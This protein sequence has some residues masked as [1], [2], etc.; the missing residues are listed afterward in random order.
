MD[1][2]DDRDQRPPAEGVRIIGAEE[3]QAALE[4]GRAAGRRAEHQ[5]AGGKPDDRRYQPGP[6]S[7]EGGGAPDWASRSFDA[8]P[9]A[10][11][12]PSPD[13]P[14]PAEPQAGPDGWAQEVHDVTD[15]SDPRGPDQ[16]DEA[17]MPPAE[18]VE[19]RYEPAPAPTVFDAEQE[20]DT[21]HPD[22]GRPAGESESTA[23]R[24]ITL[25]GHDLPHWTDPPTGEAPRI[26]TNEPEP[27][28]DDLA[29]WQALGSQGSRWRDGA[30]DWD[31]VEEL[32]SLGSEETRV[33]AL[34]TSRSEHS[35]IYSFDEDFERLEEQRSAPPT[36]APRVFGEPDRAPTGSFAAAPPPGSGEEVAERRPPPSP[37]PA[38]RRQEGPSGPGRPPRRPGRSREPVDGPGS[39][40]EGGQLGQRLAVGAALVV[41][42]LIFYAIGSA[43]LMV[44]SAAIIGAAAAEG[45]GMLQ[46]AG[47]RPATLLG[48]VSSVAIVGAAYWRGQGALPLVIAL[49]FAGSMLW[50]LLGIVDAR[51]L[52]N[53]AVTNL[54]FVWVGVLGSFGALLLRAHDGRGLFLGAVIV[55]VG[56]DIAAYFA[57]S[58][59]GNRPMAPSVSP[60]KTWEGAA[61]GL[62]AAL[63]IGAIIGKAV[64]PWGG[65]KHGLVFG[66]LVGIVGPIGDLSESMIKRD[67]GIKN[68]GTLIP[69][70][71]GLLD[72]FDAVLF[73]LPVAYYLAAWTGI[74]R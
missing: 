15:D 51:P 25:G 12:D 39:G 20:D 1:E 24:P 67:L 57:G 42:L 61:A 7:Y 64:D 50:Y 40:G 68:S 36:P 49:T 33:G 18:D 59:L 38:P 73:V 53:I 11:D 34:D 26:L 23:E 45:Y 14:G 3:A 31:D 29:A 41:L 60:G 13:D 19:P 65:M 74:L 47:F 62:V 69:G 72:R 5:G 37:P 32:E 35:D 30:D 22:Q 63:I 44:L 10:S 9:T 48:L 54:M 70:H 46:K 55:A 27:P 6:A 56:A 2:R 58:Q 71:G 52:A 4:G 17:W 21:E 66:L 43:A 16:E 8:P 28:E